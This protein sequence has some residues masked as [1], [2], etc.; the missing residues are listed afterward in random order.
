MWVLDRDYDSFTGCQGPAVKITK[1][2]FDALHEY[3]VNIL[4]CE[5]AI[6]A[7]KQN[8]VDRKEKN[9]THL[10]SLFILICKA[11]LIE[12]R[13]EAEWKALTYEEAAE[14]LIV[15]TVLNDLGKVES[16]V[17][18]VRA[19]TGIE[20]VDHDKILL[21]G[22]STHPAEFPSFQRLGKSHRK[23]LIEGL[24]AQ[25]NF[26]QLVQA[27]NLPGNLTGIQV[28]IFATFLTDLGT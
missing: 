23:W 3:V 25:F 27:E 28:I 14:A 21:M 13:T 2:S 18:R 4:T 26:A 17:Q 8:F 22:L 9:R 12:P 24:K 15:S 20:E 7:T 10:L 5:D 1:Q 6:K 11:E 16:V 19:R